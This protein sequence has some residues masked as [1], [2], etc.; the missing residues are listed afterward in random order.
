MSMDLAADILDDPDFLSPFD[1]YRPN[2]V[3]SAPQRYNVDGTIKTVTFTLTPAIMGSVQPSKAYDIMNYLPEGER[4]K[5]SITIYSPVAL[6]KSDANGLL[7]DCVLWQGGYYRVQYARLWE[8][9]SY[10]QV[11]ATGFLPPNGVL[12]VGP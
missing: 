8:E 6:Q 5:N 12:Q 4:D 11:M 2:S 1:L 9:Y 7:S 3:G 10:W